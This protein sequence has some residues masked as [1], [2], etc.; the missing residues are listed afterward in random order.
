MFGVSAKAGFANI[1][2][3]LLESG[4]DAGLTNKKG[5]KADACAVNEG[6]LKAFATTTEQSAKKRKARKK[7]NLL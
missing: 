6:T 3:Y 2:K 1:V 4:A 5:E 7:A